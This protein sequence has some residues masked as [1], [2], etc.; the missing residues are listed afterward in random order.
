MTYRLEDSRAVVVDSVDAGAVLPEEQGAS[1][2]QAPHDFLVGT[3]S[4][5]RL[6]EADANATALLVQRLVNGTDFFN[7][8]DIIFGQLA[9]PA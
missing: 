1:E 9:D 2:E 7:H 8:I 6:P 3:G 5:E 4:L